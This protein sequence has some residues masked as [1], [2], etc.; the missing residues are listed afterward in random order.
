QYLVFRGVTKGYLNT[1]DC[2]RASIGKHTRMTYYTDTSLLIVKLMP[3]VK[4]E[5]A[6]LTLAEDLKLALIGMG[7]PKRC[8]NPLG[9]SKFSGPNSS[10]EGD[11]AYKPLSRNREADWPTIV[12][13]SRLSEA[14]TYLRNDARWWLTNSRGDVRIVTIISIT[15]AQR[16]LW[17]EKW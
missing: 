16:M 9:G 4:H 7:L 2:K 5:L 10:K 8:L 11:L 14:L 1:I 13:E 15:P 6:H 3:S 12:F 17:V